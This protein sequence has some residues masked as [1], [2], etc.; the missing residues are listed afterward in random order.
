MKHIATRKIL[1][2][3]LVWRMVLYMVIAKGL[4]NFLENRVINENV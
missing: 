4:V 1:L 2:K 3:T